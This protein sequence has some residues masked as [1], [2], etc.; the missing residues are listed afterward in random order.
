MT[1]AARFVGTGW[2]WSVRQGRELTATVRDS[3][4]HS[5]QAAA[6]YTLDVM[7]R[8]IISKGTMMGS[9]FQP[10]APYTLENKKNPSNRNRIL[11]DTGDFISSFTIVR[12]AFNK[13]MAGVTSQESIEK[14]EMHENGGMNS[15]NGMEGFVPAR[16]FIR[17][18]VENSGVKNNVQNMV[19]SHVNNMLKAISEL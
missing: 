7:K 13:Y 18:V 17:P 4:E 10:L 19:Y 8:N 16:P 6:G 3:V 5:L 11:I 2:P 15:I 14:A 12:A 1:I 9:P